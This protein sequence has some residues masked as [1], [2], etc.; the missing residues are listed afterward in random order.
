MIV[1]GAIFFSSASLCIRLMSEIFSTTSTVF[2]RSVIHT[3]ILLPLVLR[4]MKNK[5]FS[6]NQ[7]KIHA[8]RGSSGIV[9]MYLFFFTLKHVPLALA[10]TLTMTSMMWAAVF[11]YVFIGERI[12]R[13]QVI[14]SVLVILGVILTVWKQD[15]NW[16][17]SPW[18]VVTGLA[19]GVG[20]GFSATM[21]RM[22]RAESSTLEVITFFGLFALIFSLGPFLWQP[23]FP[24][25]FSQ[26]GLLL[27]MGVS[28]LAGQFFY[29]YGI[30]FTSVV[31]G[32]LSGMS[33]F[34]FNIGIGILILNEH[35]TLNFM[36]G[37][38]LVLAGIMQL[39]L[40]PRLR[41]LWATANRN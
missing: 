16:S 30:G 21:V 18:G 40:G 14:A 20:M 2:Y 12:Q 8:I 15:P 36:I 1:I 29:T 35:P 25:N 19:C 5:K 27:L 11:S 33:Q 24:E 6:I 38:I 34:V 23:E 22:L 9:A 32:T 26:L 39:T 28:A 41:K 31:T 3:L 10:I 7:L 37:A 13:E 4:T 17:F